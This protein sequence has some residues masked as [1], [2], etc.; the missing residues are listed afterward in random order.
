MAWS[1]LVE[2]LSDLDPFD[3]FIFG[4]VTRTMPEA[5]FSRGM[6]VGC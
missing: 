4:L 5:W 6:N 2:R 1:F 3:D